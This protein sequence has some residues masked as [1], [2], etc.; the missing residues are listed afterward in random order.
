[1]IRCPGHH[2]DG[3]VTSV[4]YCCD[5]TMLQPPLEDSPMQ[6]PQEGPAPS[7]PQEDLLP[8]PKP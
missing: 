8:P 4:P 2:L 3:Q 5:P 7:P 6:P 1:M